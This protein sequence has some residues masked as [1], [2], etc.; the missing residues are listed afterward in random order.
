[1]KKI[2]LREVSDRLSEN[3]MKDVKGGGQDVPTEGQLGDDGGSVK[4]AEGNPCAGK[5]T[6]DPCTCNGKGGYC[7]SYPFAGMKCRL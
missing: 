3:E 5:S 7:F 6:Y 2:N 1:M 4:C